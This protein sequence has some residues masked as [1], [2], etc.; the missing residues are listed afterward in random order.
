MKVTP[1]NSKIFVKVLPE[2]TVSEGGIVLTSPSRDDV[3]R[4]EVVSLGEERELKSGVKVSFSVQKG[5]VVFFP[6]S[7]AT[8]AR[9][10]GEELV[11]LREEDIL[12][13]YYE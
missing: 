1:L 6:M 4:G 11:V 10:A 13:V 3:V 7:S 5:D 9:V 2:A 12:A 8:K